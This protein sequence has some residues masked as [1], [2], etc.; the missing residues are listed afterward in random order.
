MEN[1]TILLIIVQKKNQW[2]VDVLDEPLQTVLIC[3]RTP[4][5]IKN[6]KYVGKGRVFSMYIKN[7]NVKS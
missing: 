7:T 1:S 6:D 2:K 4:F 3:M 5:V